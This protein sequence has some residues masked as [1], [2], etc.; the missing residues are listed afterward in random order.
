MCKGLISVKSVG[1]LYKSQQTAIV[2]LFFTFQ[3][4]SSQFF[5]ISV[6]LLYNSELSKK[7]GGYY[8]IDMIMFVILA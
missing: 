4:K 8:H 2:L 7:L 3:L 5:L 1:F 6:G